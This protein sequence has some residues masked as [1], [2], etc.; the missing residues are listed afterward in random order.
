MSFKFIKRLFRHLL[1]CPNA[2]KCHF[3]A[4]SMRRIEDAIAASERTHYGEICFAVE[5]SLHVFDIFRKKSGKTRA[6][7]VF[8]NLHVWDTAQNNGVLIYLLLADH[9]FEILADRGV[10]QHVGGEGWAHICQHMEAMFRQDQ[11]EGGVLYGIEKI[12]AYLAQHYP[13]SGE[14]ANELPNVPVIL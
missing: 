3:P 5:S 11:F 12:G 10:H 8:S 14:N 6:I 2:V 4:E 9:D 7:E 1:I 13:A